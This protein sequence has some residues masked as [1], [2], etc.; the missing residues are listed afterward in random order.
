MDKGIGVVCALLLRAI[1][2]K[3]SNQERSRKY[4][5]SSSFVDA[6]ELQQSVPAG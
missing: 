3:K 4:G 5:A 1:E 6:G 2:Q